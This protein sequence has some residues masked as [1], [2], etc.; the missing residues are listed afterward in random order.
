MIV[1]SQA[2]GTSLS[3]ESGP[4]GELPFPAANTVYSL[5]AARFRHGMAEHGEHIRQQVRG[6]TARN[7]VAI[8]FGGIAV[9]CVAVAFPGSVTVPGIALVANQQVFVFYLERRIRVALRV[10]RL[11]MNHHAVAIDFP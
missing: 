7:I 3:R 8:P 5:L 2:H 11:L 1:D 9:A 10:M 6:L 4:G